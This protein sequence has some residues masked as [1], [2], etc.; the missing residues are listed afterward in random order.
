MQD[1]NGNSLVPLP[2]VV[3]N[4]VK[5]KLDDKTREFYD[6]VE[7]ESRGLV[8]DLVVRGPQNREVRL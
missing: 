4:V 3:I 8:Q 1:K 6:A 5:V 7:E 2:P